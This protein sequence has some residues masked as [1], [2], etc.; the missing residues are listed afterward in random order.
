MSKHAIE[1]VV[2][3]GPKGSGKGEQSKIL[4]EAFGFKVVCIGDILRD[5]KAQ[6]LLA[7][8]MNNELKNNSLLDD[9]Y[10]YSI[11]R[12]ELEGLAL[13][14]RIVLDG[15]PRNHRQAEKF[16]QMCEE[17]GLS[18][19]KGCR[20]SVQFV[21]IFVSDEETLERRMKRGRE[22]DRNPKM[23]KRAIRDYW[24]ALPP[25]MRLLRNHFPVHDL[26]GMQKR[27]EVARDLHL[28]LKLIQRQVL[29]PSPVEV[30]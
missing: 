13:G 15:F 5:R 2:L 23:I 6:G 3:I 21:E 7:Q 18:G 1:L 30:A 14:A 29:N 27:E 28:A 8:G 22:D 9:E 24:E 12:P 4:K 19:R 25:M 26:N 16:V 20:A 10:I 11:V 17:F